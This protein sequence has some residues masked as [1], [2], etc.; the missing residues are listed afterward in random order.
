MWHTAYDIVELY[1]YYQKRKHTSMLD[2]HKPAIATLTS[3]APLVRKWAED[4]EG[5]GQ[6]HGVAAARLFKTPIALANSEPYEWMG[7]PRIG[8]KTAE[9][10]YRQIQGFKR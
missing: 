3:K 5:I 2:I 4:L 10:I 9:D 1:H 7:I 8:E 6:T